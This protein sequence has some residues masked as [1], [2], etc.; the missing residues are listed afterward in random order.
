MKKLFLLGLV[1]ILFVACQEQKTQR[2]FSESSEIDSFKSGI[3]EYGNG[4]WDTWSS[5]YA[6]TVKFY[7]N[8]NKAVSLDEFK[9]GQLGLLSKF[10]SYG[11][12]EKGSFIEMVIDSDDET[13]VN[14]WATWRGKLKANDEEV[15]IPVHIT[16][17]YIDGKAVELH[18]YWDSAPITAALGKIEAFNNLPL[19]DKT[20]INQVDKFVN[21]FLNK[22]DAS[23]LS[24]ILADDFVRYMNDVKVAS[25]GKEL[26]ESMKVFFTGFPDLKIALLYRSPIFNNTMFIHWQLTGTNTGEFAGSPATG[27]KVK[28]SGL[29]RWHFNGDG[30]ADKEIVFFDQLSLMQ[31]LGHTLN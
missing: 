25:G 6:D 24:G 3:V 5:R 18:N 27:K 9:K 12:I 31:Q 19:E 13:W 26:A 15:S 14:Y 28:V 17:Q 16:Q 20:I 30:K 2:Y 11:F 23:A 21:V 29:A 22:Q 1:T 10:S 8:S 7:V 4:D